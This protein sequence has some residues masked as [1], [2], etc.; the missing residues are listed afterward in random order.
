MLRQKKMAAQAATVFLSRL[1]FTLASR[2]RLSFHRMTVAI[3]EGTRPTKVLIISKKNIR[4]MAS[5]ILNE[6]QSVI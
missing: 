3:N 6:M 4:P 5:V 1:S 2:F